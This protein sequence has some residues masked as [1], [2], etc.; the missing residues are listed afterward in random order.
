MDWL[1]RISGRTQVWFLQRPG[2]VSRMALTGFYTVEVLYY[3]I[4]GPMSFLEDRQKVLGNN[5][6][7]LGRLIIGEHGQTSWLLSNPQRRGPYA[8]RGRVT[9]TRLPEDFPLF[10][11][12][13]EVGGDG[14]HEVL[15]KWLF[16]TWLNPRRERLDDPRLKAII[17]EAVEAL[18]KL[19]RPLTEAA[20]RPAVNRLVARYM[21]LALLDLEIGEER[22]QALIDLAYS[23]T[24]VDNYL[25]SAAYPFLPPS[26]MMSRTWE[27]SRDLAAFMGSSPLFDGWTPGPDNNH[28]TRERL[29]EL[30]LSLVAIAALGGSGNVAVNVLLEP[31]DDLDVDLDDP[32]AV[33]AVALE[34]ARI[35]PP[36]NHVNTV[37]SAPRSFE[38]EGRQVE[39]PEG[40]CV[41]ASLGG[42][43]RNEDV[44]PD[45]RRFDPHRD[46]LMKDLLSFN[47]VGFH[48][49]PQPDGR[50]ACPGRN[51]AVRFIGDFYVAWRRAQA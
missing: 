40:T 24:R 27:R 34:G 43:S 49:T 7:A 38:I 37:L 48:P 45:A 31:D 21:M 30:L 1:H 11:H 18:V 9:P 20:V 29:G 47:A 13:H 42:A 22:L 51:V 6:G 35:K 46:N 16:E 3:S 23:E 17:D 8:A 41:A 14:Q 10:Q 50:R 28:M 5:F 2:F 39:F 12:D 33:M 15:H 19:P 44:F 26:F 32:R 4:H 36:V 25:A